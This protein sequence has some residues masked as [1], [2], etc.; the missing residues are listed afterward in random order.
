MDDLLFS[1][2]NDAGL[3]VQTKLGGG[4]AVWVKSDC[5]T[6]NTKG[7]VCARRHNWEDIGKVLNNTL[8]HNYEQILNELITT[9]LLHKTAY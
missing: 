5:A 2:N 3:C 1:H 8:I 7:V 6:A 9:T 4:D